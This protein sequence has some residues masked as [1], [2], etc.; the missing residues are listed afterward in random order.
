MLGGGGGPY[1]LKRVQHY[2]LSLYR[3]CHIIF[4]Y[5]KPLSHVDQY[6]NPKPINPKN[7]GGVLRTYSG[8]LAVLKDDDL[9][10]MPWTE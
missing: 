5:S 2:T 8:F 1:L 6:S 3:T 4:H 10:M 9:R 7:R